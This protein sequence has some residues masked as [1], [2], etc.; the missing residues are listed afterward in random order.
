MIADSLK[1]FIEQHIADDPV[2]LVLQQDKHP[3]VDLK[4][5]A[6]Q[7]EGRRKG[8]GKLPEL[9][10]NRD[11]M[12]PPK[13]NLEQC[14][15]ETTARFKAQT[16]AKGKTVIDITGGLGIDAIFFSRVAKKVFY[17]EQDPELF[18]MAVSNFEALNLDNIEAF[19]GDGMEFLRTKA[20]EVDLVYADP[21]RRDRY[22]RKMVSFADCQ[23]DITGNLNLIFSK[24]GSLLIK[25]SPMLDLTVAK[26]ELSTVSETTVLAV[27]NECKE[28][29]FLCGKTAEPDGGR[30]H[31]VNITATGEHVRFTSTFEKESQPPEFS[32]GVKHYLYDPNAAVSKA[33]FF[34]ALA[35][36][37]GL[38]KLAPRT[39][40]YTSDEMKG[41]FPGRVFEVLREIRLSAKE[42]KT[43]LPDG[44]AH[45]VTRNYPVPAEEL[46]KKL[47]LSEGSDSYVVATTL[48]DGRKT[49]F[50][51][52]KIV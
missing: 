32:C 26:R 51:C 31:C 48:H 18:E 38:P 46:Q 45:V 6:Q 16:F 22:N 5:V 40:L 30:T 35:N 1:R 47:G 27:R 7:I 9:S 10:E 44:K 24:T 52:R 21:A 8:R 29:L 12:F 11:F 36:E 23:P 43:V 3:G 42:M 17:V 33:G 50:L 15:S 37:T 39:H 19:C 13:L 4:F 41:N 20:S 28:L 49:G 14:S 34:N 25:A 2:K